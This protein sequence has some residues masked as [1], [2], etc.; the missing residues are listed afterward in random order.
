MPIVSLGYKT[1][2]IH[3]VQK[4]AKTRNIIRPHYYI[5]IWSGE[6]VDSSDFKAGK[7]EALSDLSKLTENYTFFSREHFIIF[8]F[9]LKLFGFGADK[10]QSGGL[11]AMQWGDLRHFTT[12]LLHNNMQRGHIDSI[13][14]SLFN[15]I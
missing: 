13:A 8:C 10:T 4:Y 7:I 2:K 6:A 1:A 5:T 11:T 14:V 3:K 9:I 15:A 12:F